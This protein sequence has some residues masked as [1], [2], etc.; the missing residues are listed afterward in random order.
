M[1]KAEQRSLTIS[2]LKQQLLDKDDEIAALKKRLDNSED[3]QRQ[4]LEQIAPTPVAG[5]FIETK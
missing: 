5:I 3:L 1:Y 4:L 2:N